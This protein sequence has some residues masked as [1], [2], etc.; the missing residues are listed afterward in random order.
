MKNNNKKS[1]DV[2]TFFNFSGLITFLIASEKLIGLKKNKEIIKRLEEIRDIISKIILEEEN[3]V[4]RDFGKIGFLKR[5]FSIRFFKSIP[6]GLTEDLERK[7]WRIIRSKED[8]NIGKNIKI[9]EK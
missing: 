6:G 1:T 3:K 8:F 4:D 7:Y 5:F 9:N 2:D